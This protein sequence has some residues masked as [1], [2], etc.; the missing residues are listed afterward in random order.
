VGREVER[1]MKTVEK[2]REGGA[3]IMAEQE[4]W[5]GRERCRDRWGEMGTKRRVERGKERG[6]ERERDREGWREL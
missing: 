2:K 5:R 4:N 1:E 6:R 3:E